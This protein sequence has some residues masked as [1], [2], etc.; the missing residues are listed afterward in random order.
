MPLNCCV[1]TLS[2]DNRCVHVIGGY[3]EHDTLSTH[4]K[5]ILQKWTSETEIERE[6]I[7]KEKEMRYTEEIKKEK[8][9]IEMMNEE[10]SIMEQQQQQQLDIRKL[11][12]TKE[13]SIIVKY[14]I[15][16]Y[17]VKMG[18]IAEFNAIIAR[19]ILRKHYRFLKIL[20]RHHSYVRNVKL[21]PDSSKIVLCSDETVKIL[22]IASEKEIGILK[23]H[24]DI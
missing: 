19:Y 24:S 17:S 7:K 22:S 23:R 4:I 13:I 9:E 6:W 18:W 20:Q 10:L 2:K 21:S 3:D 12:K 14:W 15:R 5:T 11:K 1:A 16:S 8:K